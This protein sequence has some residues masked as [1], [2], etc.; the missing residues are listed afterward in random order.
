MCTL[1]P[2]RCSPEL[3]SNMSDSSISFMFSRACSYPHKKYKLNTERTLHVLYLWMDT[4]LYKIHYKVLYK[5]YI[6]RLSYR[7]CK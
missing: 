3:P 7:W 2:T 6:L 1:H 5:I 4:W